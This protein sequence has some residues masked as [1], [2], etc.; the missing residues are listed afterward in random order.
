MLLEVKNLFINRGKKLIQEE[1]K[2]DSKGQVVI[3]KAMRRALKI[4]PGSKVVFRLEGD[5]IILKR[6]FD[7][8]S[9]FKRIVKGT[10]YNTEINPM[11]H[12]TKNLKKDTTHFIRH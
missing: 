5:K 6:Y 12:T 2:V 1:R 4:V 7:S 8:V 11:K 9:V 3:A 10:N